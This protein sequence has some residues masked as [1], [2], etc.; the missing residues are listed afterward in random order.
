MNPLALIANA[1]TRNLSTM[2]PGYFAEV[3]RNHYADFGYPTEITFKLAY[4]AYLRIGIAR[5]AVDKTVAKTWQDAPYIQMFARDDGD[6]TPETPIE[7]A[8]RERLS[9]I[10]VW[11]NV[12]ECDRRSLVGAYSG[13]ILRIAD[14][15]AFDQPVGAVTGGMNAL[16]E[17]IPAWE[18]QLEVAEWDG[19]EKSPDYGRP[20]MYQFNEASVGRS[21]SQSRQM[22]IHPDRVII[23]SR[24]G[25]VNGRSA[26]EPGYNDLLAIEKMAQAMG[27]PAAEVADLMNEQVE[28]YQKGF[29]KMLLLQGIEAK[30]LGITLPSPEHFF[31]IAAQSFAASFSIPMKILVGSQTGERAS[32]EDGDEWNRTNMAR[33]TDIA[34]P[35]VMEMIRRFE[36]F[37]MIPESPWHIDWADLTEQS[38]SDKVALADKM[39]DVNVKMKDTGEFVFT[40][41]EM[42]AVTGKEPLT[43]A[44]KYRDAPDDADERDA[45]ADQPE[46]A[47]A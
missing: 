34:V 40:P 47:E 41:D 37:G 27:V 21:K 18:G 44:D 32:T 36:R 28:D 17:V 13:L 9:D 35:N 24:D 6:D 22:R 23:W 10:R 8:I 45:L 30:T 39:A 11:Q 16:V 5:A 26:L 12:A 20:T 42:R 31:A 14:S 25:T 3:K 33:R 29:D 2:F 15:Q 38:M 46:P 7:A 19:D 1:V 4:D 43:D